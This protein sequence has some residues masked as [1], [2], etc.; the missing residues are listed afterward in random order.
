MWAAPAIPPPAEASLHL[1]TLCTP[2]MCIDAPPYSVPL[3]TLSS[4]FLSLQSSFSIYLAYL[5]STCKPTSSKQPAK[6]GVPRHVPHPLLSSG[7][8]DPL[9]WVTLFLPRA[10]SSTFRQT[11]PN[12]SSVQICPWDLTETLLPPD[13]PILGR[14]ATI[15]QD[16]PAPNPSYHPRLSHATATHLPVPLGLP[17]Q[18]KSLWPVTGAA[19]PLHSECRHSTA[20]AGLGKREIMW[21]KSS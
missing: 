11:A 1:P 9:C 2:S 8:Q 4:H 20:L 14:G 7:V 12:D 18:R 15:H 5:S 10:L 17:A 21:H 13:V 16:T 3:G 19:P 6:V